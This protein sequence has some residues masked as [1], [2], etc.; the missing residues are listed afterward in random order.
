MLFFVRGKPGR[1]ELPSTRTP[2]TAIGAQA[3]GAQAIKAQSIGGLAIGA[4]AVGA[5]AIGALAL[6]RL[7]IGRLTIRRARL[8]VVEIEELR[9]GRR[10]AFQ[11]RRPER[12]V[13]AHYDLEPGT[14]QGNIRST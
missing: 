13:S 1:R 6:G 9:V 7:I 8:G 5:A 11:P 3:I 2:A 10:N 14:P 12:Q 4:L